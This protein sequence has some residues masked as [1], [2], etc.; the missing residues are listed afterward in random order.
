MCVSCTS[1]REINMVLLSLKEEGSFFWYLESLTSDRFAQQLGGKPVKQKHHWL[2]CELH[3]PAGHLGS[4]TQELLPFTPRHFASPRPLQLWPATVTFLPG[5]M[6]KLDSELYA[7][8]L[9]CMHSHRYSGNAKEWES[10]LKSYSSF[11]GPGVSCHTNLVQ[12]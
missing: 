11:C 10:C 4:G 8:P 6:S 2:L 5:S 7:N 12:K 9:H 1:G 3:L